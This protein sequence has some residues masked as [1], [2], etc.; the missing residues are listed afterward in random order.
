MSVTDGVYLCARCIAQLAPEGW[1]SCP[2]C[3]GYVPLAPGSATGC[4]LC[5][6]SLF[7][8]DTAVALGGYHSQLRNVVFQMKK[9]R[10]EL[11]ALSLGRLL[12]RRNEQRLREFRPEAVVPVPMHWRRRFGR[13]VNGPEH[14]AAAISRT[15]G[16]PLHRRALRRVRNTPPQAGLSPRQRLKNVRGAFRVHRGKWLENRRILLIDDVLTTGATCSEAARILKK[17]GAG[18]VAVAVVARGQ[19]ESGG[20]S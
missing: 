4:P 7:H 9:P 13:G 18:P 6:T 20:L 2:K 3:G 1:R 5:K 8:F 11:L 10:G 16:I 17:A 12:C 14:L 15:L 19:G